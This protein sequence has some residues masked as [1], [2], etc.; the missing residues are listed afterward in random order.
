MRRPCAA[1]EPEG[2]ATDAQV[3][4]PPEE[5]PVADFDPDVASIF[6][7]EATELLEVC[8]SQLAAWRNDPANTERPAA[9]KRPLHTLKGGARMAGITAMGDLSHELESLVNLIDSGGATASPEAF[10]V[11][12]AS[13]DELARMRDSVAAGRGV[14]PARDCSAR[15][16]ALLNGERSPPPRRPESR[17]SSAAAA[18]TGD[19]RL[20]AAAG[21]TRLP[22]RH[23]RCRTP[24]IN[25][26]FPRRNRRRLRRSSSPTRSFER[27]DRVG[28][29]SRPPHR[30]WCR[31]AASRWPPAI[32]RKWRVSMPSCSTSC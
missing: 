23:P 22:R 8:E 7:E 31:R 20:P 29:R 19:A 10:D 16:R 30:S 15:I 12:Q 17:P 3:D 5:E 28:L 32:G 24:R 14:A 21:G 26:R 4:L 27:P 1:P 18:R 11:L 2:P 9:L 13:V 6:T 25:R